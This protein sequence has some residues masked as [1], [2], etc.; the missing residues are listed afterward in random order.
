MYVYLVDQQGTVLVGQNIACDAETFLR[1]IEPF[2]QD[3][4]VCAECVFCWYWLADLCERHGIK[5]VLAHALYLKAIHRG[6][7]KN[8]AIDAGKIAV[9]LRGGLIPLAYVYPS[10]M[11]ATRDLLRRRLY[12]VRLRAELFSHIQCTFHQYNLVKPTGDMTS[13]KHR[14][15]L[16]HAF[17]DPYDRGGCPPVLG[18][19]RAAISRRPRAHGA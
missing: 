19:R 12:I 18:L 5:F 3:L 10:Q 2:R 16:A 7:A 6:K 8:D 4:V 1:M 9:L 17:A 13:S 14:A 11:R 15:N